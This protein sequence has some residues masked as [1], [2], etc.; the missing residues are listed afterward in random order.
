MRDDNFI[1]KIVKHYFSRNTFPYWSILLLDCCIVMASGI[2]AYFLNHGVTSIIQHKWTLL[3]TLTIYLIPY[4]INFKLFHTYSGIIRFSSFIDLQRLALAVGISFMTDLLLV[5]LVGDN[6]WMVPFRDTDIIM[7]ALAALALMLILRIWVKQIYDT[8]SRNN[9]NIN[10]LIYGVKSGGVALAKSINIPDSP[11]RLKGFISDESG[12]DNK[13]LFGVPVYPADD[14]LTEVIRK[15]KITNLLVSPL[16]TNELRN[17]TKFVNNLIFSGVT[18]RIFPD[19]QKWDGHSNLLHTTLKE[20]DVND[21]LPREQINL[22]M[23]NIGEMLRG[24]RIIVTGAAGSIG[25]EITRQVAG[26]EPSDLVLIDQAE[27]PLHDIRIMMQREYPGISAMTIVS[28]ICNQA[29]METLF[30][31]HRPQYVFHAAA[32]KHVPMMEDNPLEAIRNNVYGTKVIADLAVKY[33]ANKFVMIS[34]DK[35]VNPTNIMGCSKRICE[36]YVQSLDK[37]IKEGKIDGSTQ[38]VTTRFGNVLGSNGSVIPLFR[39]Q[40]KRGG[41][42]TVTHPD[43]IRYFM[44]IPEACKLVLEAGSMGNGG[45]IY[46][47]DMGSPVRIADLAK[48]MIYL[49]GA[50][51]IDIKYTGLREGEKLYEELLNDQEITIPTFHDKIKIAKVREY[52][53]FFV[54]ETI[55]KMVED[56]NNNDDMLSVKEMKMLVPE[57]IST[58]SK[59]EVLD[60]NQ[61]LN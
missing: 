13:H 6:T 57:F 24:K 55:V 44:L 20:V 5:H 40:I 9:K 33:G 56:I 17:N 25:A 30:R 37:A 7:Q 51:N 36:I 45:E 60:S 2:V 28:D 34:T 3:G 54:E 4:I 18:I 59:Y 27:T 48:R 42:V 21:L 58:H 39:E 15:N 31:T 23:K 49:S 38:F 22:D 35:A 32:Y 12:L 10:T 8:S 41:P 29:R 14:D 61:V 16:K 26:F 53:F 47:F 52:D 11:Y 50:Q 46:V 1:S 19:A 43:I